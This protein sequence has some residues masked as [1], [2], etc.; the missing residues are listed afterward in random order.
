MTE[1]INKFRKLLGEVYDL[2][3]ASAVLGWDQQVNMPPGG[4]EE[5]SS[6]LATLS[7]LSHTKFTSDE[8]LKALEEARGEASELD[9]DS[10]EARL[11]S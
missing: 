10:D 1:K 11:V 9:P 8:M 5:R 2:N 7:S 6:Q 3:A 4:A